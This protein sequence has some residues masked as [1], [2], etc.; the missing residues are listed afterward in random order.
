MI[1]E[2][3]RKWL[4][5]KG[6]HAKPG[7]Y[8]AQL[9]ILDAA[10]AERDALRATVERCR[11]LASCWLEVV[12]KVRSDWGD[13]GNVEADILAQCE[14]ELD[15]NLNPPGRVNDLGPLFRDAMRQRQGDET[16]RQHHPAQPRP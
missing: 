5:A 9:T 11:N 8:E 14:C 2:E 15:C 16:L 10:I 12:C 7:R 3:L 6:L 4:E 13:A 1:L